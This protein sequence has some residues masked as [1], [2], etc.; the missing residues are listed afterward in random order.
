ML[1][2]SDAKAR[3]RLLRIVDLTLEKATDLVQSAEAT[4]R[5]LR[6]MA[7]DL[8]VHGIGIEKRKTPLRRTPSANE[9][10]SSSS[11]IFNC[12]N[13]EI[14]IRHGVRECTGV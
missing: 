13:C 10:R 6:D 12:R 7:S 9:D 4:E 8:S 14:E 3:E 1:G 5:P 2:I 11:K